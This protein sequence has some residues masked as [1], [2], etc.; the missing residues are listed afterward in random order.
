MAAAVDRGVATATKMNDQEKI[1]QWVRPEIQAL[2]AYHVPDASGLIKLDAKR[3]KRLINQIDDLWERETADWG[4]WLE[5]LST[6]TRSYRGFVSPKNYPWPGCSNLHIPMTA[7]EVPEG[8]HGQKATA[9][10]QGKDV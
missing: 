6:W 3:K 1:T 8:R 4:P 2:S 5:K 10:H 9:E 7:K